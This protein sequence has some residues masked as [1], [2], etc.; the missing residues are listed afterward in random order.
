MRG[1]QILSCDHAKRVH[2]P[3]KLGRSLLS[4]ISFFCKIRG[5]TY[6]GGITRVVDLDP[7]K[8]NAKLIPHARLVPPY[9][10]R[11]SVKLSRYMS[12]I[13]TH[14]YYFINDGVTLLE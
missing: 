7:N 3:I 14:L 12:G 13:N 1:P 2:L 5:L 11:D 6:G 10:L 9:N 8:V 4:E